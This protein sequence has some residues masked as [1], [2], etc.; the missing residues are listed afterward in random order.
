MVTL[1]ASSGDSELDPTRMPGTNTGNL[2]KALVGLPG[3]LL[4]VPPA[5]HSLE[6]MALG[7]TNVVDHLI[8]GKVIPGKVDIVSK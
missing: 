6:P 1:P 4:C 5:G 7:H 2:P 3:Q 8:L